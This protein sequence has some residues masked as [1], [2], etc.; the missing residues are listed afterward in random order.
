MDSNCLYYNEN[1]FEI[2][3]ETNNIIGSINLI[4]QLVDNEAGSSH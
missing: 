4:S 1:I 3:M 2:F